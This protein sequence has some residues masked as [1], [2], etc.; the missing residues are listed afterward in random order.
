MSCSYEFR[1]LTCPAQW[2][3]GDNSNH[4]GEEMARVLAQ[5]YPLAVF[6]RIVNDINNDLERLFGLDW[7]RLGG[8]AEWFAEHATHDVRVFDEYGREWDRCGEW[9]KCPGAGCHATNPCKLERGHDGD[10]KPVA[11]GPAA[12]TAP[13]RW[14]G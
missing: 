11:L 4:S 13:S 12:P 9:V 10:H 6:G 14:P 7:R 5:R 8:M 2:D 3:G 1:C